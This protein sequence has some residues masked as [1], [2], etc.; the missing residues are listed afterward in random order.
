MK[1]ARAARLVEVSKQTLH[2]PEQAQNSERERAPVDEPARALVREDG[3]E[4]PG[5]GDGA[6]EVAFWGRESVGG[7]CSFEEEGGEEDEYFGP[8]AGTGCESI[9]TKGFEEGEDDEDG[10]PALKSQSTD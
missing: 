5:D 3:E 8:D 2:D 4:G 7:G 10:C 9:D 6:G 1:D